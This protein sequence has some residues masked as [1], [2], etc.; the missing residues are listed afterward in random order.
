MLYI[1]MR[2]TTNALYF[3]FTELPLKSTQKL[4]S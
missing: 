1:F 4:Y 2:D 3:H